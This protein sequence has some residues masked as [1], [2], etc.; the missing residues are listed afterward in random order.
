VRVRHRRT[1]IQISGSKVDPGGLIALLGP[2]A[3]VTPS[4]PPLDPIPE[5]Y[6]LGYTD[7]E[8]QIEVDYLVAPILDR[9][10]E[11]LHSVREVL[12]VVIEN[13][14]IEQHLHVTVFGLPVSEQVRESVYAAERDLM[15]AFPMK[16]FDFHL[17]QPEIID[18]KPD[19]PA[20]SY[21][22]LFWRRDDAN[23]G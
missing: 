10:I 19:I 14:P 5:G 3:P 12:A 18:G 21:A 22:L 15:D 17:R 13:G 6:G 23:E 4:E 2:E 16:T 8:E 11:R 1:E 20:S 7:A 9:F